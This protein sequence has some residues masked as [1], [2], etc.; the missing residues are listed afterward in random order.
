LIFLSFFLII[1][2]SRDL[3]D[4]VESSFFSEQF[5]TRVRYTGAA[6]GHQ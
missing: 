3:N 5:S 4:A 6:L 1:N 2:I